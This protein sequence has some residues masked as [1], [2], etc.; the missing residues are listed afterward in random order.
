MQIKLKNFMGALLAAAFVLPVLSHAAEVDHRLYNE[1][2]R[3]NQGVRSGRL[4]YREAAHL[5]AEKR[6]IRHETNILRARNGGTLTPRERAR[7]NRQE[8]HLSHK[9]YAEKHGL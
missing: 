3:I 9:V 7:I 6:A 8:N 2:A 5:H 4:T 1:T